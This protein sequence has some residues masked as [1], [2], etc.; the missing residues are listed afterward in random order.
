MPE[1]GNQSSKW[2]IRRG[3][4]LVICVVAIPV[5]FQWMDQA[6]VIPQRLKRIISV[7]GVETSIDDKWW[8]ARVL[9]SHRGFQPYDVELNLKW[10]D[11]N[12]SEV[13]KSQSIRAMSPGDT[14]IVRMAMKAIEGK[15]AEKH[16]LDYSVRPVP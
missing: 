7:L 14:V 9:V 11:Q 2:L 15:Q 8:R 10:L 6:Y 4:A 13:G 16:H 12:G 5:I 3:I 1:T